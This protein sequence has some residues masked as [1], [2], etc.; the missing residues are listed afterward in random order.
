MVSLVSKKDR[1]GYCNKYEYKDI[2]VY[3]AKDIETQNG[4]L[5]VSLSKL[6]FLKSLRVDGVKMLI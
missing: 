3:I 2:N 1:L 6:L 5:L 4:F